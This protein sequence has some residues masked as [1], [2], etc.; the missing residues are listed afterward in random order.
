MKNII[1]KPVIGA[2]FF[3]RERELEDLKRV[4]EDEHVLLLAPRRVGKTSLLYAI[5]SD[6]ERDGSAVAA[7]ASVAAAQSEPQFVDA[8]LDAIHATPQGKKFKAGAI[9]SWLDRHGRRVKSV[10]VAGTGVDLDASA[11]QWQRDADRAFAAILA[12]PKPWLI[13]VDELP[14]MVLVLARQDPTG[15]RL[16]AFLLWFRNLRQRVAATSK[17]R[18]VLAGSIGLD[19]VA[20]RHELT[21]TINDLRDWRLGPYDEPTAERFLTRLATNYQIELGEDLRRRMCEHAE[22]LIPYHLQVIFSA[23]RERHRA[24]A[25]LSLAT[26]EA[27]V[28][29]LLKRKLY[30]SHWDERLKGALG[31]PEDEFARRMLAICARDRTGATAMVL[32]Q[33]LVKH[34]ADATKRSRT[35]K[36]ILDVLAN[37]GYL[38][39][40]LG[41]WRFRSGLL[42]RYW[43]ENVV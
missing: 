5:A 15:A 36:W 38:V 39:E 9:R 16:R 6:V 40:H 13:L 8:V 28:A 23:F 33:C 32:T 43:L 27:A 19:N 30:F 18:F 21:D 1:G 14:T 22:W 2:D 41:R 4:S 12:A 11:P 34:V 37:D 3:G 25:R 26:L 24:G 42:R 29:G 35:V 17:L 31:A 7:Y 20:R 10:N